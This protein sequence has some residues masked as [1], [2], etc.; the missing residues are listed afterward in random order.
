[1]VAKVSKKVEV[2]ALAF[3]RRGS[4]VGMA[5]QQ[6]GYGP[7][8]GGGALMGN[9]AAANNTSNYPI[10]DQLFILTEDAEGRPIST[11]D[12][13]SIGLNI[14]GSFD[15]EA[16]AYRFNISQ[17]MQRMLN[18]ELESDFLH[19]VSSR[20]GIS[21]QGVVIEGPAPNPMDTTDLAPHARLVVTWSD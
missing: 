15:Q 19:V 8:D 7:G 11:P 4:S 1:V 13:N 5:Q 12:Q 17:T 10:P 18:G 20:A 16:Q 6:Q 9:Q 2:Q 14:N 21:L 3:K